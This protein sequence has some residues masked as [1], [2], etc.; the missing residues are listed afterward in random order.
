MRQLE[1]DQ[2]PADKLDGLHATLPEV[3][4]VI[5]DCLDWVE[6]EPIDPRARRR[7][8]SNGMWAIVRLAGGSDWLIL[9]EEEDPGR[10]VVRFIGETTSL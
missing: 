1:L 2:I 9:W 3:A 10:P 5:E 6:A 8:F 4:E 7:R